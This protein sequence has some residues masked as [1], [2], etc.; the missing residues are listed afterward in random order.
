MPLLLL[1]KSILANRKREQDREKIAMDI[2]PT[3]ESSPQVLLLQL[4]LMEDVCQ[5]IISVIPCPVHD[6][7]YLAP[8]KCDIS[9]DDEV[10]GLRERGR[11]I[12]LP[13][14]CHEIYI[15]PLPRNVS[16][17]IKVD[18]WGGKEKKNVLKNRL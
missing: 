2:Y 12:V 1:D 11:N 6:I 9:K 15:I 17:E 14:P 7:Y 13:C 10:I 3:H 4:R 18:V 5:F 16:I 8:A